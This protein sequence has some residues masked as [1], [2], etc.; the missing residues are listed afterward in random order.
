MSTNLDHRGLPAN[1]SLR[2]D[3]IS[4]RDFAQRMKD[5]PKSVLL[6]DVRTLEEWQTARLE[7]SVHVPLET[8]ESRAE[9][10]DLDSAKVVGI[11]C[12]HGVRSLRAALALHHMGHTNALSIFGGIEL[13]SVA[14]DPNI[15]RYSR[16]RMTGRCIRL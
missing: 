13:W 2:P 11:L 1:A 7:G 5:D 6:I 15:P 4:P 12:H 8:I 9:D 14:V 10:L 3:E 16:D